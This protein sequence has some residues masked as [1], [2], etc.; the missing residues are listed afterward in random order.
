MSDAMMRANARGGKGAEAFSAS[1]EDEMLVLRVVEAMAR[2]RVE[3]GGARVADAARFL[4]SEEGR[5]G[6][7]IAEAYRSA[8]RDAAR[9]KSAAE[10]PVSKPWAAAAVPSGSL[11]WS[12]TRHALA[13]LVPQFDTCESVAEQMFLL[14]MV[15]PSAQRRVVLAPPALPLVIATNGRCLELVTQE[16]VAGRR[17]DFVL[18]GSSGRRV[19]I[20]VDGFAYHERTQEQAEG[21][22]A[23]DRTLLAMGIVTLRFM[24]KAVFADPT[25]CADEAFAIALG[26]CAGDGLEAAMR[27]RVAA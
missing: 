19:A 26:E 11:A 8:N 5:R 18:R 25:K 27:A 16:P 15:V 14:G 22:R 13:S 20:E 10:P 4:E 12:T 2:L 9:A 7:A 23:R 1:D 21:D 24:A 3:T 6:V 17:L